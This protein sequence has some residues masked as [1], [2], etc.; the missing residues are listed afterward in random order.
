MSYQFSTERFST[1]VWGFLGI[2][3]LCS[4]SQFLLP[5]EAQRLWLK[6]YQVILYSLIQYCR[7]WGSFPLSRGKMLYTE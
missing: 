1:K 2:Y 6:D 7:G 3:S 5:L 4:V